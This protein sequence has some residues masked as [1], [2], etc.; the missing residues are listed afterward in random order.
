[1]SILLPLGLVIIFAA[2][3]GFLYAEGIWGNFI[4]LVNVVTAG[5]LA[6]NYFEPLAKL[7]ESYMGSFTFFLDFLCLWGLFGLFIIIF[8]LLT[9]RISRTK[10]RFLKLAEQIGSPVMA[11]MVGVV[12]VCFT[13]M[14]LHTAPLAKNFMDGGFQP[15]EPM[16]MGTDPD[17]QWLGFVQGVSRGVYCRGLSS[18]E[19]PPPAV[20]GADPNEQKLAV[21]DRRAEFIPKYAARRTLL[22]NL[23]DKNKGTYRLADGDLGQRVPS[24]EAGG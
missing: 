24:R 10:V 3:M 23:N 14:T 19:T 18:A 12:M 4:H 8:R 15:G 17:R 11:A 7:G 1:M 13:A 6:T 22:E 16:L 5:L 2:C 21:F 20:D 9:D